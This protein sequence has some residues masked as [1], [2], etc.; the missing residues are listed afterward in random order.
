MYSIYAD[1]VCVYNDVFAVEDMKAISPKLIME[2]NAAG[3]LS[4]TLTP[5]NAGYGTITR[6]VSDISVEKDGEEIWAGR[7]LSEKK[8]FYNKR[9]LYCEGF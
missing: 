8:D 3:S 9:I 2:D 4:V 1:G 7:V 5:A 6:L